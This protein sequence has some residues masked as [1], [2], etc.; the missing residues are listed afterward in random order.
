LQFLQSFQ[1]HRC[2]TNCLTPIARRTAPSM[3]PAPTLLCDSLASY[4][5]PGFKNFNYP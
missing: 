4:R 1:A 2:A 3:R 5:C